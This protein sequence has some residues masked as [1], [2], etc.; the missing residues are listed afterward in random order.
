MQ[1]SMQIGMPPP[2][3]F[4]HSQLK[5]PGLALLGARLGANHCFKNFL[6]CFTIRSFYE[7]LLGP[8]FRMLLWIVLLTSVRD[9]CEGFDTLASSEF[10]VHV[11]VAENEA[12]PLVYSVNI[13]QKLYLSLISAK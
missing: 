6:R 8:D 1:K 7:Y 5:T 9:F 11:L 4:C 12:S 10:S 13:T 2:T 3:V